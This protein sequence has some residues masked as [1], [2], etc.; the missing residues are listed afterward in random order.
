MDTPTKVI[1]IILGIVLLFL[2]LTAMN[3]GNGNSKCNCIGECTCRLQPRYTKETVGVVG[4]YGNPQISGGKCCGADE[5]EKVGGSSFAGKVLNR[6]DTSVHSI[7]DLNRKVNGGSA[8]KESFV[9]L[10]G[11]WHHATNMDAYNG[12]ISGGSSVRFAERNMA[13]IPEGA[14]GG[15]LDQTHPAH[16]LSLDGFL[17]SMPGGSAAGKKYFAVKTHG[18]STQWYARK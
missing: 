18:G 10:G 16:A 9:S 8:K 13:L 11:R 7:A 4:I 3:N 15:V 5:F 17:T 2:I 12:L 14:H 1:L 6:V